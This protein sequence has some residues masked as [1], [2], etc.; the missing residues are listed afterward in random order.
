MLPAGDAADQNAFAA[1]LE[2][3]MKYDHK[4]LPDL[5][6]SGHEVK[7]AAGGE[8]R[9]RPLCVPATKNAYGIGFSGIAPK[10]VGATQAEQAVKNGADRE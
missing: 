7:A 6:K 1:S 8:C 5:G 4:V 3:A 9:T 10:G 2:F